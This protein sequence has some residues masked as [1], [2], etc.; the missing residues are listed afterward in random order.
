MSAW[1]P[2]GPCSCLP[3]ETPDIGRSEVDTV[4][5]TEVVDLNLFSDGSIGEDDHL[6]TSALARNCT[7]GS[8]LGMA[9]PSPV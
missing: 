2:I 8:L 7:V 5:S 6:I 1:Q 4:A 9:R 3:E